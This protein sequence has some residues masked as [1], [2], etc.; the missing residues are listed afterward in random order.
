VALYIFLN[1]TLSDQFQSRIDAPIIYTVGIFPKS[2]RKTNN[3]TLS[4]QFPS[5]IEKQIMSGT[6]P[7]GGKY[8]FFYWTL[9]LFRQCGIIYFSIGPWNCS[10]SWA[11]LS[12]C[13][14]SRSFSRASWGTLHPHPFRSANLV[15]RKLEDGN[16]RAF[17]RQHIARG[18]RHTCLCLVGVGNFVCIISTF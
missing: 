4:Q 15:S 13:S 2:H 14:P 7:T 18:G 11:L 12:C 5:P 6:V 9:E 10:D 3:T 8:L 17:P 1:A 16:I